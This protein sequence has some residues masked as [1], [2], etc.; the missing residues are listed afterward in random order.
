MKKIKNRWY[1]ENQNSWN[2]YIET[3]ESALIKSKV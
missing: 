3:E 2:A 1:D